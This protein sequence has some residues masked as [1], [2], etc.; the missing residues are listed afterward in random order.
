MKKLAIAIVCI[1]SAAIITLS[2]TAS[3]YNAAYQ[4][5][6]YQSSVVPTID[7]TYTTNDDWAASLDTTFGTNGHFRT[8]WTMT[9]VY[10]NFIIETADA[11][12]DA[13]DYWV[14]CFDSTAA[15][16]TT[17][18]DAGAAPQATDYKLVVTGHASPTVQWYKG[19]GTA[20][21]TTAAPASFADVAVFQ[22]AQQLTT[23]PRIASSHYCWEM[24]I[25]KTNTDLGSVPMGYNWA[26]Y[27]AYYDAT[28]DT[29]QKWPP[30]ATDTN[31]DSWGYIPYESVVNPTPD[32]PENF[33]FIAVALL[34]CFAVVV[35]TVIYRKRK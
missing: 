32:V 28:T 19:T 17:A 29:T 3:A 27:V 30:A 8:E 10:A 11:T 6:C 35:G 21:T 26:Q 16:G 22:Q 14:I 24:H 34:S 7:G 20:W 33:G 15:G 5:T 25:D 2:G 9:P 1:L 18:P 13:G 12:N 23:T 4:A 31:P